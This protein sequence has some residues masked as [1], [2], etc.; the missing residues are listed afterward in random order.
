MG[1]LIQERF[2]ASVSLNLASVP[3]QRAQYQVVQFHTW[4]RYQGDT[5]HHTYLVVSVDA[6][7]D[8]SVVT[9]TLLF[10]LPPT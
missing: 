5:S 6:T 9:F 1:H 7:L 10:I 8:L 4:G 2:Q 3:P